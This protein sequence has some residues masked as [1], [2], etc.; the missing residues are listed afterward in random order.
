MLGQLPPSST[1]L[2]CKQRCLPAAPQIQ[3]KA[4]VCKGQDRAGKRNDLSAWQ[5]FSEMKCYSTD[6]N[7]HASCVFQKTQSAG[8]PEHHA[9]AWI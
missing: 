5:I 9:G 4:P 3:D 6:A 1:N 7:T 8:M 2:P